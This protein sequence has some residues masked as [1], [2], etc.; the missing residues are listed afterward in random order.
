MLTETGTLPVGIE[1]DGQTHR[2]F[3][4]REQL[5]GDSVAVFDDQ[6]RGKRA[7]ANSQYAAVCILANQI[8][9]PGLYPKRDDQWRSFDEH[10]P[11]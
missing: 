10:A 9:R 4:I 6:A 8:T 7:T 1:F 5:V 2:E 11:G 3:E